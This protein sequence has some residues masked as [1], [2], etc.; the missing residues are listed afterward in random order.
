MDKAHMI[1]EGVVVKEGQFWECNGLLASLPQV[2][3]IVAIGRKYVYGYI[4]E[5]GWEGIMEDGDLVKLV[6]EGHQ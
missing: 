1:V 2:V 4:K 5:V 6:K 3:E